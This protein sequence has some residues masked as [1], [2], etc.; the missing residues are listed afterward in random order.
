M[1]FTHDCTLVLYTQ[2]IQT[3][4][5]LMLLPI[6]KPPL[7]QESRL[8]GG[9]SPISFL[10]YFTLFSIILN[11]QY[12]GT[13]IQWQQSCSLLIC[14]A[15]STLYLDG[16]AIQPVAPMYDYSY[17]TVFSSSILKSCTLLRYITL[18]FNTLSG[19]NPL[20]YSL[21]ASQS[22]QC[23]LDSSTPC[24]LPGIQLGHSL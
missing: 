13:V 6:T 15:R 11:R 1:H 7:L 17:F 9:G 3:G 21:Y 4:S 20:L 16:G 12:M 10:L 2:L 18:S 14:P 5:V 22:S 24:S 19:S 23:G 8:T